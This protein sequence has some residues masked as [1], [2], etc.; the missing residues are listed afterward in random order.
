MFIL[1]FDLER[2]LTD[3][4]CIQKA[5]TGREVIIESNTNSCN[6]QPFFSQKYRV[7]RMFNTGKV[8]SLLG[9]RSAQRWL[10]KNWLLFIFFKVFF[11][12]SRPICWQCPNLF[13]CGPTLKNCNAIKLGYHGS[14][15]T[16][17]VLPCAQAFF[18]QSYKTF[19]ICKREFLFFFQDS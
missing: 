13:D 6:F 15:A 4:H 16:S 3:A 17:V 19:R 2:L 11:G 18:N 5:R 7:I 12:R 1:C 10:A 9:A 8:E 14:F